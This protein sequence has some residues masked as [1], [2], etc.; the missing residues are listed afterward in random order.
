MFK[1]SISLVIS[2]LILLSCV[3]IQVGTV[4]AAGAEGF[5]FAQDFNEITLANDTTS[6]ATVSEATG[7][8]VTTSTGKE[9]FKF[10]K[11]SDNKLKIVSMDASTP[12]VELFY[13]FPTSVATGKI[14]AK[15]IISGGTNHAWWSILL[16]GA[17]D[18]TAKEV[19]QDTKRF[20]VVYERPTINDNWT[21]TRYHI[22]SAGDKELLAGY[23]VTYS[24]DEYNSFSSV[25]FLT[26]YLGVANAS[27]TIDDLSVVYT[28]AYVGYETELKE[29]FSEVTASENADVATLSE[30]TG[31]DI[32]KESGASS[33]TLNT[34]N[35][36]LH[37]TTN[38]A[39]TQV[40]IYYN[41]P[42]A[43]DK[44][45]IKASMKI[46]KSGGSG[47]EGYF[48]IPNPAGGDPIVSIS[49]FNGGWLNLYQ[50]PGNDASLRMVIS[51]PDKTSDWQYVV[52]TDKMAYPEIIFRKTIA[53]QDLQSISQI[54]LFSN[55]GLG[56]SIDITLDDID[57]Q[58]SYNYD[59]RTKYSQNFDDLEDVTYTPAQTIE[60]RNYDAT[61]G[62]PMQVFNVTAANPT[63]G[64]Q[65]G[66][67]FAKYGTQN[68][69][70]RAESS[71]FLP[72][73]MYYGA[74]EASMKFTRNLMGGGEGI[75]FFGLNNNGTAET[76]AQSFITTSL[77]GSGGSFPATNINETRSLRF[78][79][80]RAS[81]SEDW[82]V[83]FFD[84]FAG[85]KL[86]ST[87]TIP[88]ANLTKIDS[89]YFFSTNTA[90]IDFTIDDAAYTVSPWY[91][92]VINK[93]ADFEDFED[94][95]VKEGANYLAL[96][97]KTGLSLA[98]DT[99]MSEV[100]KIEDGM[101][102][103]ENSYVT[104]GKYQQSLINYDLPIEIAKGEITASVKVNNVE[105]TL[106]RFLSIIDSN[107][108]WG[109]H[110]IQFSSGTWGK[111]P[112]NLVSIATGTYTKAPTPDGTGA[113]NLRAVI[114][115][116]SE[117]TAW[118]VKVYDDSLATPEV[119]ATRTVTF[120]AIKKLT[121][122]Q[123]TAD[124][125][126]APKAKLSLDSFKVTYSDGTELPSK[127]A[128]DENAIKENSIVFESVTLQD[129]DYKYLES[130]SGVTEIF[131]TVR[132]KNPKGTN[133]TFVMILAAYDTQGRLLA[134][135]ISPSEK[136]A[137]TAGSYELDLTG[138]ENA[139]EVKLFFLN[140]LGSI[141]PLREIGGF[142]P[143][144]F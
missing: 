46:K 96:T 60:L 88:A 22:N 97:E 79:A 63:I 90:S 101:L 108:T 34:M 37:Y 6:L 39:S 72:V 35:E 53:A 77:I 128:E 129:G 57:I 126:D 130:L 27:I 15:M 47:N 67:Y 36:N 21:E 75:R 116:A 105:S 104:G 19:R 38:A 142:P 76:A 9:H 106:I 13:N 83:K 135:N 91:A 48:S 131:A 4:H 111:C 12:R 85:G 118:D 143:A 3:Y 74:L 45:F 110:A 2:L 121:I 18:T 20:Y 107:N 71:V 127:D 7:L 62:F 59:N 94:G 40:L 23:P 122:A 14:E 29:D 58:T 52:Y 55:Y 84:D 1:K 28:P 5:S 16:R 70:V 112:D 68:G 32:K 141:R 78:L 64:I 138:F 17:K 136:P 132:A 137:K 98:T 65:D 33:I 87:Q 51:R 44:G 119:I 95:T 11:T 109:G 100:V 92:D 25:V 43:I 144:G 125:L 26:P 139:A 134:A 133:D 54:L 24:K 99:T 61:G 42:K 86:I 113:Y 73:P 114:S 140:D 30:E 66:K 93:K 10:S 69:Q 81:A 115:R 102:K 124:V 80:Y 103:V 123:V 41:L 50:N 82:T 117:N 49:A 31:L 8:G 56:G 120:G 89:F